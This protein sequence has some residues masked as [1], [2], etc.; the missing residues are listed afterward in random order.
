MNIKKERLIWIS[1]TSVLLAVIAVILLSPV[2]SA[3]SYT[4]DKDQQYLQELEAAYYIIKTNYVDEVESEKIFKGAINGLF[5]SLNDPYSLYLDD[6][7]LE[8]MTDTTKGKY[9]GVG[10]YITRD[11]YDP[12]NPNGHLP[13]VKVVAPIEDTPG[14]KAGINA[15]DYIYA[16]DGES[17]EGY[18]TRDVSN[19]LRG[20]P[21]TTVKVTI[22]RDKSI[23]FDVELTRQEIEIP[24]VKS[25]VI[26]NKTG[27]LRIIEFTPYTAERVKE[28]LEKFNAQ[29]LSS[30]IVD[31]RSNPG[32]LLDSVVQIG[33]M[34]FS[35]GVIVSTKYRQSRQDK[36]FR[37]APGKIVP[38][39]TEIAVLIDKGS[40]S[41]SE[42]L[43]GALKDRGR[44]VVIGETSFGK[45]SI[46]QMIPLDNA[47]IKITTGRYYT[48]S[49]IS[50][51]KVGI[52]PDIEIPEP[53]LT[54][55][56]SL[57]Y[58][59]LLKENRVGN[60]IDSN[61]EPSNQQIENFIDSLKKEGLDPGDRIIRLMIKREKERRMNVPPVV[62]LEFDKT[63]L[64]AIDYLSEK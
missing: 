55:E 58:A 8:Q 7:I 57:A 30:L 17:A 9:G 6:E 49:G 1:V 62:D 60:F 3:K 52:K 36:V 10:L 2:A 25:T 35:G 37:A 24:T 26:N 5:A 42:I 20:T 64:K 41:A 12:E 40:A 28:T 33:D 44:A 59:T 22:L 38:S 56:Q 46:Q 21:G 31:V 29:G 18:T 15:G 43:T 27:Y 47:A 34:F 32:G 4:T 63:L 51:D 14:W 45:G 54:E 50:I 23:T 48:P 53:E 13:Y 61:P 19:K 39:N 16:I 11:I